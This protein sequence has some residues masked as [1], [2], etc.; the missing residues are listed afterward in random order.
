[1]ESIKRFF[2]AIFW[3]IGFALQAAN[4]AYESFKGTNGVV[5]TTPGVGAARVV[6]VS[7][8]LLQ[9]ASTNL[10]NWSNLSTNVITGETN[11]SV[12]A[13]TLF[14]TSAGSVETTNLS[15][16]TKLIAKGAFI[17]ETRSRTLVAGTN[18]LAVLTN[19]YLLLDSPTN[20]AA[21]VVVQIGPAAS[22]GQLLFVVNNQTNRAFTIYDGSASGSGIVELQGNFVSTNLGGLILM[23]QG[24]WVEVGRF[25]PGA[26]AVFP[27]EGSGTVNTLSKWITTNRLGDSVI[28]QVTN[29]PFNQFASDP[30]VI[31][32]GVL[33]AH[34]YLLATTVYVASGDPTGFPLASDPSAYRLIVTNN[35]A[36]NRTITLGNAAYSNQPNDTVQILLEFNGGASLTLSNSGNVLMSANWVATTQGDRL[37]LGWNNYNAKWEEQWRY[38]MATGSPSFADLVWTN[39]GTAIQPTGIGANTNLIQIDIDGSVWVGADASAY[40]QG[41]YGTGVGVLQTNATFGGFVISAAS[42]DQ[43]ATISADA[44]MKSDFDNDADDTAVATFQQTVYNNAGDDAETRF[45]TQVSQAFANGFNKILWRSELNGTTVISLEPTIAD[46]ATAVAYDYDT[47]NAL[48]TPGS[49]LGR[50]RN[51][52]VAHFHFNPTNG[53]STPAITAYG[54]GSSPWQFGNATNTADVLLGATNML[55]VTVGGSK[56][57]IPAKLLP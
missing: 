48:V 9:P 19:S 56:Y 42:P 8:N 28:V 18:T 54:F 17:A 5:L 30:G 50:I 11:W 36:T 16:W 52:G 44:W 38:P 27:L 57:A 46:G 35:A 53:F 20:D 21:S 37:S 26:P 14:P 22:S 7:G 33:K 40:L 45:V 23:N 51:Q 15:A 3:V 34:S 2:T 12:S 25:S 1:M 32:G 6:I 43:G 47:V 41:T 39:T 24:N 10:T 29:A 31:V 55:T 49:L 13:G 4:P